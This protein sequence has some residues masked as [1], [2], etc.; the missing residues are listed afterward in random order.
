MT[1]AVA[2]RPDRGNVAECKW[3]LKR[4]DELVKIVNQS[5]L[6]LCELLYKVKENEWFRALEGK[7]KELYATF[8]EYVADRLGWKKRKGQYFVRIQKELMVEAG[9]KRED[10]AGVEYSKAEVLTG[11]P[12][13]EKTPGRIGGWIDRA[14]SSQVDDLRASVN[15]VRNE[16]EKGKVLKTEVDR[17]ETFYVTADQQTNIDLALSVAKKI[18]GPNVGRGY[19]LDMICTE[20]LS[21]RIEEGRIMASRILKRVEQVFNIQVIA[22][23]ERGEEMEIVYGDKIAKKFGI[24]VEHKKKG[25]DIPR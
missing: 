24:E 23:E 5:Y 4:V 12:P 2:V 3:T 19:A 13:S 7:D 10:L 8:E 1:D 15:K 6:E 11:L 22:F 14:R 20:F 16:V 21:G 17:T 18:A 25:L 9:L